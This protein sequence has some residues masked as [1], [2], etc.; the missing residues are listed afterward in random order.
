MSIPNILNK[1][2]TKISRFDFLI[3]GI[4]NDEDAGPVQLEFNDE[5]VLEIELVP[6]GESVDF[7]WKKKRTTE[8]EDEKTD[9]IRIDLTNREPFNLLRGN[10]IIGADDLLFG[11]IEEKKEAMVI[12][13]YGIQFDNGHT[14]VYYNAGDFAKIYVDEMPKSFPDTFKLIWDKGIFNELTN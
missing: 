6:D 11:T 9:W 7:S 10:K 14:L 12:A 1:T 8:E 13:G 2:L 3:D 4:E 5:T